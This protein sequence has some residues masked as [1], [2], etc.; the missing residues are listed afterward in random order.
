MAVPRSTNGVFEAL[1]AKMHA[2]DNAFFNNDRRT[3]AERRSIARRR[4]VSRITGR[5]ECAL[6]AAHAYTDDS[7]TIV[8]GTDRAVRWV[9]TWGEF[10]RRSKSRMAIPEKRLI[11]AGGVWCG[12][13]AIPCIGVA[14]TERV[15][16]VRAGA[17]LARVADRDAGF[18]FVL[19]H[20]H[21]C[22]K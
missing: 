11:G 14:H 3:P 12:V 8:A 9:R 22:S 17:T 19:D 21:L 18:P 1:T 7:F 5:E 16:T 4:A 20:A 6:F 13:A 15:K 2:A 10:V